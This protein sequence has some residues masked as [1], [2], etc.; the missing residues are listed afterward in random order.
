MHFFFFAS[1]EVGKIGIRKHNFCSK[2]KKAHYLDWIGR[3]AYLNTEL[4]RNFKSIPL[5]S[6]VKIFHRPSPPPWA[7]KNFQLE[8]RKKCPYLCVCTHMCAHTCRHMRTQHRETHTQR[9]IS[10]RIFL[11]VPLGFHFAAW[12]NSKRKKLPNA[13]S[14]F[15]TTFNSELSQRS[16]SQQQLN[17]A[18]FV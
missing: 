9:G 12:I 8:K 18:W 17:V 16:C 7:A 4:I 11:L 13:T 15:P 2:A 10:P 1:W 5:I 3:A 6:K 14:H